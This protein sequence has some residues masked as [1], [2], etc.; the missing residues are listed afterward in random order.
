MSDG[1]KF[2]PVMIPTLC[3]YEHFRRCVESL[4]KNK[5]SSKTD[6]YVGLDYPLKEEH[7][8]GYNKIKAYLKSDIKGFKNVFVIEREKNMGARE[9]IRLLREQILEKYDRFIF[10]E[11]D[12]EF[13]PNFLEYMNFGL[14]KYENDPN[15]VAI[16]GYN[17]PADFSKM[18]GNVYK[19][20]VYCAAFGYGT[21]RDKY[22][23][24]QDEITT[25]F[26]ISALKNRK[27][28]NRLRKIAPN[29]Y[30][31]FIKGMIEY[32]PDMYKDGVITKDD[33]SKGI[34]M[35]LSNSYVI[36]PKVSM[37][38]N[39]GYDGSGVNCN[40]MD[41]CDKNRI[42]HRNFSPDCQV[43]DENDTFGEY[44]FDASFSEKEIYRALGEFFEVTSKEL[45]ASGLCIFLIRV[46]GVDKTKAILKKFF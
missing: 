43:L 8:E 16:T 25:E 27:L 41:Y 46:F 32:T 36:F 11:D 21:W 22:Y 42:T 14:N 13:S 1:E 35:Y 20:H 10:T 6:L 17:Y 44:F 15:A 3:R 40:E 38:R 31:N 23:K 9:N 37:V 45:L 30:C 28:M 29:Q 33:L 34:H 2:A 7:V 26:F 39:W 18:K 24:Q 5:I 4:A 19:N 12:N